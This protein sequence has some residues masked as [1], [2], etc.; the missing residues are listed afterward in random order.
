MASYT[1]SNSYEPTAE[2]AGI[3]AKVWTDIQSR[4]SAFTDLSDSEKETGREITLFLQSK[5]LDHRQLSSGLAVYNNAEGRA[6]LGYLRRTK[7]LVDTTHIEVNG[8]YAPL[9]FLQNPQRRRIEIYLP[10]DLDTYA[11]SGIIHELVR[12]SSSFD[13][14]VFPRC[15][16]KFIAD[17]K[18]GESFIMG[19]ISE[20]LSTQK[21]ERISYTK[22]SFYQIGRMCARTRLLLAVTDQHKISQKYLKIP[23]RY[24]GGTVAFK[25]PEIL[26]ALQSLY[27]AEDAKRIR[28]LL[29]GLADHAIR[30]DTAKAKGKIGKSLFLPSSEVIHAFKR[31]AKKTLTSG[32]KG[33]SITTLETIDPTKPSQ[34]ATVAPWEREAVAEIYEDPWHELKSLAAKFDE[35]EVAERDYNHFGQKVQK[36]IETMWTRKQV[37]LKATKHRIE[38]CPLPKETPLFKKLNWVRETLT[39]WGTL[40]MVP[41]KILSDFNPYNIFPPSVTLKGENGPISLVELFKSEKGVNRIPQTARLLA[42]WEKLQSVVAAPIQGTVSA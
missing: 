33:R 2:A 42:A 11:D 29:E 9:D 26:R 6:F 18:D 41:D 21:I 28:S 36:E 34:L 20:L 40:E 12:F 17:E 23:E 32:K 39:E 38:A 31:R 4:L 19:Y 14:V 8:V 24:L 5:N 10:N 30:A 37:I 22:N 1:T 7:S 3:Q 27:R 13:G 16:G 35:L 15:N 25:D